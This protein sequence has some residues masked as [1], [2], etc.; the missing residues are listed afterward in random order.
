MA[1]DA[2]RGAMVIFGGR[3]VPLSDTWE[4]APIDLTALTY[5]VSVATGG[6]AA[7]TI[8]AGTNHAGRF[9][10]V[11][12]CM[13]GGGPRGIPSLPVSLLLNPDP[14]FWFNLVFPNTLI[15]NSLGKLDA[16]GK[17]TATVQVPKLPSSL[18]GFRFYHA[19]VVFQSSIDYASTP[20]PLTLI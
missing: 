8:N 3:T 7:L 15:Q 10:L 17:A 12:G 1:F 2:V 4:Y 5:V 18:I 19:Y 9:Y 14:Y 6:N 20:V 13:D 11:S 16:S